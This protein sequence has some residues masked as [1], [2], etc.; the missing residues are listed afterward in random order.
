MALSF[1]KTKDKQLA[2]DRIWLVCGTLPGAETVALHVRSILF[3]HRIGPGAPA[4]MCTD[5]VAHETKRQQ[6]ALQRIWFACGTLPGS[7]NRSRTTRN[8]RHER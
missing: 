6:L 3:C 4:S 2:L 8:S 5:A 1:N 7:R